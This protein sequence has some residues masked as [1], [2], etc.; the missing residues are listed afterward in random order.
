MTTHQSTDNTFVHKDLFFFLVEN[1]CFWHWTANMSAVIKDKWTLHWHRRSRHTLKQGIC[2]LYVCVLTT[3][4]L[5]DRLID[6]FGWDWLYSVLSAW[7]C[8]R[9]LRT[10]WWRRSKGALFL[11]H[12][13]GFLIHSLLDVDQWSCFYAAEQGRTY[14]REQSGAPAPLGGPIKGL[15]WWSIKWN[16]QTL[17]WNNYISWKMKS[18]KCEERYPFNSRILTLKSKNVLLRLFSFEIK[19][20]IFTWFQLFYFLTFCTQRLQVKKTK[21]TWPL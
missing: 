17:E 15:Q 16:N 18:P 2:K 5:A 20:R 9:I 7:L 6:L 8:G 11:W 13:F 1:K 19:V 4:W 3:G 12:S 21:E 14:I 10:L